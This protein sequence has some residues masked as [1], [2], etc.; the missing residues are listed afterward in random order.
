[1]EEQRDEKMSVPRAFKTAVKNFPTKQKQ[2]RLNVLSGTS[3]NQNG[4]IRIACPVGPMIDMSEFLITGDLRMNATADTDIAKLSMMTYSVVKRAGFNVNGTNIGYANNHFPELTHAQLQLGTADAWSKSNVGFGYDA[5]KPLSHGTGATDTVKWV[6]KFHPF[7]LCTAGILD[8]S[9]TGY[10]E[11]DYQLSGANAISMEKGTTEAIAGASWSLSNIRS[12][13]NVIEVP[14][15]Y[16]A[17]MKSAVARQDGLVKL[18]QTAMP[19]QQ[20]AFGS[21]SF[22]ISSE[23]LDEVMVLPKNSTYDGLLQTVPSDGLYQPLL[24]CTLNANSKVYIQLNSE[25]FPEYGENDAIEDLSSGTASAYGQGPYNFHKLFIGATGNTNVNALTFEK[26]N[27]QN[28]NAVVRIPIGY[29]KSGVEQNGL[30]TGVN[31]S[32]MNSIV[33]VETKNLPDNHRLIM[34]GLC[35]SKLIITENKIGF[36]Q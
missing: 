20:T 24:N 32:G 29:G 6:C 2:I 4:V 35:T 12:Y 19:Y 8:T 34:V 28:F 15:F 3:A 30:C 14:E 22:N 36:I 21:N 11:A 27:Y 1:M 7:S 9:S 13:V 23:C 33:R 5:Q 17:M 10:I 31:T 25:N 18:V 16:A 26:N